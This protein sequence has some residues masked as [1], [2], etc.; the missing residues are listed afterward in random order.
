MLKEETLD[1]CFNLATQVL[2]HHGPVQLPDQD[3]RQEGGLADRPG[4]GVLQLHL[5]PG[6]RLVAPH[7]PG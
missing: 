6:H 7:R 4:L 1:D 3:E 2:G 5:I